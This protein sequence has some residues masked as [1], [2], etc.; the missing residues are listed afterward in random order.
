MGPKVICHMVSSI[1][2]RLHP[3]R[4]TVPAS[5][6]DKARLRQHYD[7]V[8]AH[9]GAQGWMCGRVTMQEVSKGKPRQVTGPGVS[10]REPFVGDQKDR[11]LAIAI[12][13][14][15]RV[16]YGQDN[17]V[18]DHAVA[19]LSEAV[20]DGYLAELREDGVSY[21]LANPDGR[22]LANAMDALGETFGV[23]AL[24]LEGGA[25]I[26]GALLKAGLIDE[27]NVLIHPAA[28][29]LAGVE[30][31]FGYQGQAE[32][33]PGAGQALRHMSA[34]TLEGGMVWLRYQAEK[35]PA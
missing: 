4:F 15:G 8:A 28:D 14:E 17:H 27:I 3:S 2:G 25:A 26:N 34:E 10:S 5:G 35:A 23:E 13:P 22:D 30:S 1:N 31:I 19:V 21:L 18:G 11:D 32:E 6:V 9:F 20:S 12:D 16:H 29:G 24:L 7:E 33:R